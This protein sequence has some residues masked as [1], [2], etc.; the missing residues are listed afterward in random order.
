MFRKVAISQGKR[1]IFSFLGISARLIRTA[2]KR[3]LVRRMVRGMA[4][5]VAG[6]LVYVVW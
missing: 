4:G 6:W 5:I 3:Q 2:S 1:A